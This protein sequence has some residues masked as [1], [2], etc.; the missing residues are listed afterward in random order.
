MACDH[1]LIFVFTANL[2]C[3]AA[4][5]PMMNDV[6]RLLTATFNWLSH[7]RKNVIRNDVN[8][9]A[10]HELCTWDVPVGEKQL[11]PF[12]VTK[13]TDE[14]KKTKK[15]GAHGYRN[16]RPQR[17]SYGFKSHYKSNYK[18]QNNNNNFKPKGKKSFLTNSQS[19]KKRT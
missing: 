2:Q 3:P 15:L 19:K 13:K 7:A 12:D 1:D 11:F 18:G 9:P 4:Y 10:M 14:V 6:L 8:D 5:L 17:P 16:R